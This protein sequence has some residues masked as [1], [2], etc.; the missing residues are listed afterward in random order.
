[1]RKSCEIQ[2]EVPGRGVEAPA[3]GSDFPSLL[4]A[5]DRDIHAGTSTRLNRRGGS[6]RRPRQSRLVLGT[7]L[8][9]V[10]LWRRLSTPESPIRAPSTPPPP[11]S[12]SVGA[13][14]PG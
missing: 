7:P 4:P 1:M 8:W 9:T 5:C 2:K 10:L 6:G 14:A 3:I 13:G 12:S 11:R